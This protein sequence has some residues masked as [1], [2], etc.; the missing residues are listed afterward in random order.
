M[1]VTHP[2]VVQLCITVITIVTPLSPNTLM[3]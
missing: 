1:W 3:G 2:G